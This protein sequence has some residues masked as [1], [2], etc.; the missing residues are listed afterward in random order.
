MKTLLSRRTVLRGA[1]VALSLPWLEALAPRTARAAVGIPRRLLICAF[2]NGAPHDWWTNAPSFGTSLSGADFKLPNVLAPFAPIKHKLM[3]VSRLG[4]YTWSHDGSAPGPSVE[5]SHARCM[6]AVTTCIDA[7]EVARKAGLPLD[8]AVRSTTSVDQLIARTMVG[9]TGLNSLQTGLGVKPGFFDYRSYAYNQV[10]SWK[11]P[12]EPLKRNVNPRVVFDQLVGGTGAQT[13]AELARLKA[14]EKSVLDAVR[15][16]TL[17]IKKRV[18]SRDQQVL[19]QYLETVRSLE[20]AV[21]QVA[22]TCRTVPTPSPVPEPPGPQQGLSQGQD[23]YDHELHANVMNDLI[24]LAFEC[25]RTRVVTHLL[26]DARSEF[27]YRNIPASDR[28]RVGL[29]YNA[30]ASLHYHASQHGPGELADTTENGQY[31]ILTPSNRDFAAIN[32]WMG[33]KVAELALKLDAIP[34]GD[35][36]V[37]DHTTL[38]FLSEMRT[39]DH[40][41]FDLPILIAGGNGALK[42][43]THIAYQSVGSDRQLRDLWYTLMRHVFGMPVS[44]FGEDLRG[45]GNADLTEILA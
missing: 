24:T 5:P 44:S 12:T 37:L 40:D 9:L 31:K 1:G 29:N 22:A 17:R 10:L 7:D 39:H 34:E 33:R 28:T 19:D 32:A 36:T 26:D 42:R 23:G 4:N 14:R 18:S 20:I 38:V 45:V 2:P 30:G 8:S 3:M 27:E 16:D 13:P 43:D 41:A 35:G 11:S 15:E 25:D 6:S 21:D